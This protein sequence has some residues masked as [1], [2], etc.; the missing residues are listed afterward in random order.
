MRRAL[1]LSNLPSQTQVNFEHD[2]AGSDNRVREHEDVRRF[3]KGA[4]TALKPGHRQEVLDKLTELMREYHRREHL[5][6][7]V[8]DVE[9]VP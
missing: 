1:Q 6:Q 5:R 3:V 4:P 7:K 2:Y 8:W 9:P